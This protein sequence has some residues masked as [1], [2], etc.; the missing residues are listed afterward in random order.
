MGT[1][2]QG[3]GAFH[4]AKAIFLGAEP[5]GAEA[6]EEFLRRECGADG[7]LEAQVRALLASAGS[8]V[9]S[10]SAA[11]DAAGIA[12]ACAPP[13]M[14]GPYRV[15]DPLGRGAFGAVYRGRDT[16]LDRDV[17]LKVILPGA[18]LDQGMID[19]FIRG[20]RAASTVRHPCLVQTLHADFEGGTPYLV[21]ELI[22]GVSLAD[23]INPPLGP[24]AALAMLA[25]VCG[26]LGA[27]HAEGIVHRDVKP[28]NILVDRDGG[29]HI[30]D[31]GLAELRPFGA[32]GGQG[33]RLAG[34]PTYMAPECFDGGASPQTDVYAIAV[35]AF[36]SLTGRSPFH[37]DLA[38]LARLHRTEPVP[39][40]VLRQRE[41]PGPLIELIERAM[42]KNPRQRQ[43]SA[44]HILVDVESAMRDRTTNGSRELCLRV[45]SRL[46]DRPGS[47][48]PQEPVTGDLRSRLRELA[49]ERSA[50]RPSVAIT[51]PPP[52]RDD[53]PLR[54]EA[55]PDCGYELWALP[56]SGIC[57]ECGRV[58][59]ADEY[60]LIGWGT[61]RDRGP[62]ATLLLGRSLVDRLLTLAVFVY[63]G[64]MMLYLAAIGALPWRMA[65]PFI[66]VAILVGRSLWKQVRPALGF[67]LHG[68][69]P[70][71]RML[72]VGQ[73]GAAYRAD[74]VDGRVR[75]SVALHAF[76]RVE[77]SPA[78]AGLWRLAVR[79][80]LFHRA[81]VR[82]FPTILGDW[83]VVCYFEGSRRRAARVRT[84]LR[85]SLRAAAREWHGA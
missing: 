13:E 3:D 49:S 10:P 20:V 74:T 6:R 22:D 5:L 57:P 18:P 43:R 45:R 83:E 4:R 55:C 40:D 71:R 1:P 16:V 7:T 46:G 66:L 52:P 48:D 70:P 41:V 31:L 21:L 35:T 85:R 24:D 77:V 79:R 61:R 67:L 30:T 32:P 59:A 17:A 73:R 15:L 28:A 82:V 25:G 78:G 62:W 33:A 37:G 64:P 12:T 38:E 39:I 26:G 14:L 27:L 34:T 68:K 56:R 9:L 81:L 72:W 44:S 50:G 54:L 8:T 11:P 51:T 80:T 29:I 76:G 60:S 75:R 23:L 19:S 84:A 42:S 53:R 2:A 47:T 36:E 65:A 63:C 58:Y 69:I